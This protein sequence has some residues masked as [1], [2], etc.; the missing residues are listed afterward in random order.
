MA[1]SGISK[2]NNSQTATLRI[3]THTLQFAKISPI[4]IFA[5]KAKV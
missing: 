3:T 4:H 5:W 2:C 1:A